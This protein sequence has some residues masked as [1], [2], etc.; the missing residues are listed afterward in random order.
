M[1]RVYKCHPVTGPE[2]E[3][4]TMDGL[5]CFEECLNVRLEWRCHPLFV[6]RLKLPY[7]EGE[8]DVFQ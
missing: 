5:P 8:D 1:T 7:T 2:E 3:N 4:W 6:G